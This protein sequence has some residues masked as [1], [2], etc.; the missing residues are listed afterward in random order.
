MSLG[1]GARLGHYAVT[2]KLGEGS[3]GGVSSERYEARPA[4]HLRAARPQHPS[5]RRLT[6]QGV[7][8]P[9]D[10][11]PVALGGLR[12]WNSEL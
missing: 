10:S 6:D 9:E 11:L 2:A 1:V 8:G 12:L 4:T 5:A 7:R 3:T